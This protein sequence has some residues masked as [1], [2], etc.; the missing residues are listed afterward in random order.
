M[1]FVVKGSELSHK[2]RTVVKGFDTRD[3]SS[4][5]ALSLIEENGQD[6]LELVSR[7]RNTFF[8]ATVHV[9]D[10][11]VE[12]GDVTTHYV[13]GDTVRQLATVIPTTPLDI[14]F[15]ITGATQVFNIKYTGASL[16][17]PVTSD[18]SPVEVLE[19]E[20]LFTAEASDIMPTMASLLKVL[21]T[22]AEAQSHQSSCLHL[23]IEDGLLS[24]N[25]TDAYAFAIIDIP[26]ELGELGDLDILIQHQQVQALLGSFANKE[27]LTFVKTVDGSMFGYIDEN[28]TLALVSQTTLPVLSLR[29]HLA[30]VLTDEFSFDVNKADL[31]TAIDTLGK[32]SFNDEYIEFNLEAGEYELVVKNRA[33]DALKVP[34][35]SNKTNGIHLQF[36]A[37]VVNKAFIASPTNSLRFG[38]GE[39]PQV[40]KIASLLD[41][42]DPLE[43]ATV[44]AAAYISN[45]G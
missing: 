4:F 30:P 45:A 27:V 8:R 41:N 21:S 42:G 37:N 35:T 33:G 39:V 3:E 24:L 18:V 11:E 29:S 44:G 36:I 19:T 1:K 38:F 10:V 40:I 26:A 23:D 7:S 43:S 16:K 22:D 28:G 34:V 15:S 25:A 31:K 6:L 32:L 2:L 9:T 14:T 5:I 13:S 12:D 20:E 17:L